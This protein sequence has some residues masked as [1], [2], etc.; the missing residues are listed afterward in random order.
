MSDIIEKLVATFI[1]FPG[2]GP[3]QAR[4]FVYHLLGQNS[5]ALD[6][7]AQDLLAL[8]QAVSQC[9][10]CYRFFIVNHHTAAKEVCDLCLDE[11]RDPNIL[12]VVEKDSDLEMARK[13]GHYS[14]QFFVLGGLLPILAEQPEQKIRINPLLEKIKTDQETPTIESIL[15]YYDFYQDDEKEK[16]ALLKEIETILDDPTLELVPKEKKKDLERFK[17][18]LRETTP[19]EEKEIPKDVVKIFKGAKGEGAFAFIQSKKEMSLDDG[20]NALRYLEDVGDIKAPIKTFHAVSDPLIFANVLKT[21]MRDAPK[22]IGIA[23]LVILF[24]LWIDLRNYKKV[25]L[26]TLPILLGEIWLIGFLFLSGLK[27]DFY[28]MVI[29]PAIM[30]MSIDNCIH[31]Y[32]RY[33]ETGYGS[34]SKVIQTAGIA[35][36]IASTTNA[37]GFLGLMFANHGG[38]A[39]LGKVAILGLL[40]TLLS[41]VVFFPAFLVFLEKRNLKS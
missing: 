37:L 15:S 34:I 30:G 9:R 11:S 2:I 39:S 26:V 32:H 6:N 3:R 12:M 7:L 28:S 38:L 14:G 16:L 35:S 24:L 13:S 1:R 10:S 31:I 21:M 29:V 20:Q 17:Q 4:R 25:L 18:A 41:T 19:I 8:K 33:K 36:L 27:L 22:A 40:A 5:A 23:I